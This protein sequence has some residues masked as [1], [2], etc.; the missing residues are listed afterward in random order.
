MP[1]GR[2]TP[3]VRQRAPAPGA[4]GYL[5][6]LLGR[7][8]HP[9]V[10]PGSPCRSASFTPLLSPNPDFLPRCGLLRLGARPR[11][12]LPPEA[13]RR[14]APRCLGRWLATDLGPRAARTPQP[15]PCAAPARGRQGPSVR[16][17]ARSLTCAGQVYPATGDSERAPSRGVRS[18]A[19]RPGREGRGACATG[20]EEHGRGSAQPRVSDLISAVSANGRGRHAGKGAG[21]ASRR[22]F[23]FPFTLNGSF[24]AS[25]SRL[26]RFPGLSERSA[27][28]FPPP[29]PAPALA[30]GARARLGRRR[31]RRRSLCPEGTA[32]GPRPGR[33]PRAPWPARGLPLPAGSCAPRELRARGWGR[34]CCCSPTWC[35]S[36]R[37]CP[38]C[39]PRWCPLRCRCS[40]S[41]W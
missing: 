30:A 7:H 35:C 24:L 33:D 39:R 2:Q 20:R 12:V 23:R 36:G 10:L 8:I 25:A 41:G 16:P 28:A 27:P 18:R 15:R 13:S 32:E 22:R 31:G 14:R 17:A 3:C 6:T 19:G 1:F 21:P 5:L 37:P 4:P 11:W 40:G 9:S 26:G 38:E 29:P 34:R